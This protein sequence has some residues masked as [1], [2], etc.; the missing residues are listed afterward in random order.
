MQYL[1]VESKKCFELKNYENVQV[2]FHPK[3]NDNS[4]RKKEAY[5]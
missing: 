2:T 1:I 5:F 3:T 4:F